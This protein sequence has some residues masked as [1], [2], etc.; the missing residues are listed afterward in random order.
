M[1]VFAV[2]AALTA[3]DDPTARCDRDAPR[4]ETRHQGLFGGEDLRY[5]AVVAGRRVEVD[6]L[7]ACFVST[8]YLGEEA[9]QDRPVVFL[10]NG[11]P[12]VPAAWLHVGAFGPV[13][14]DPPEDPRAP[15]NSGAEPVGN[16][17]SLLDVADL[18]FIDPP[19]TGY[20]RLAADADRAAAFSVDGDAAMAAQFVRDWLAAQGREASPVFLIGESYGTIRAARMAQALAE[21]V[22][23]EGVALLGQALNMI[24]TSQRA[25]NDLSF[26]A[27]LSAMTAIADYHGLDGLDL[28][29]AAAIEAAERFAM[30]EYLPALMRVRDLTQSERVAL[31][32]RLSDFTGVEPAYFL[33]NH[34]KITKAAFRGELLREQGLKLAVYDARYTGPAATEDGER[35]PDPFSPVAALVP[36]ALEGHMT[37]TLGVEWPFSEYRFRAPLPGDWTYDRT[38]GMS[39]G[40]FADYRYEEG[41]ERAFAANPDFRVFVGT[42]MYDTTTTIGPAR[43]LAYRADYAGEDG[44]TLRE[45]EGGHM[46]YTNEDVLRRLSGDL[47]AFI[48]ED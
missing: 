19:E 31:A 45:Y 43:L 25:G 34:L 33:E 8:A 36:E 28:D 41:L 42:G 44:F 24:E 11:G 26:A 14:I 4:F 48:A 7:T 10:F 12:I 38:G 29:G 30:D 3:A 5:R 22:R 13:R 17:Y 18:V 2:L 6:G 27:N 20:S 39:G 46:A 9:T 16:A 23:L 32:E 47:R 35:T 40:P 1:L 21:D 15:V 37:G